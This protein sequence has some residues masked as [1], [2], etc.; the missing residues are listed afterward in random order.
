M[1]IDR[2]QQY[3]RANGRT[4]PIEVRRHPRARRITLQFNPVHDRLSLTLPRHVSSREGFAFLESKRH[5]IKD[6]LETLPER[7]RLA[8]GTVIP[9]FGERYTIRHHPEEI[10]RVYTQ[11]KR[12]IVPGKEEHFQRKLKT[13]LMEWAKVELSAL[14]REKA[15][16][17]GK[18]VSRVS[19]RD[20]RTRWGSCSTEGN[21][22]FCWRLIFAPV[23]VMDYVVAHEIAHLMHMDH[24][25][26]FWNLVEDMCPGYK[27]WRTWLRQH[28]TQ[29]YRYE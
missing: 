5:W 21:V 27:R 19:V 7:T 24:S 16:D 14:A 11:G 3:V 15:F 17:I 1:R 13:F 25:E 10:G 18:R 4:Y 22:S 26:R 29:L 8:D 20:T 28:G 9:V 23:K 6:T 12:I 2:N